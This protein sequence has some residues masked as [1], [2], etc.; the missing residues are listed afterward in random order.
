MK[1]KVKV[2]RETGDAHER[3]QPLP[4]VWFRIAQRRSD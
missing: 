2:N 1:K 3:P 4:A